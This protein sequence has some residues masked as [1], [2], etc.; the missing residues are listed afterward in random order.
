MAIDLW[1][2]MA[3]RGMYVL[4]LNEDKMAEECDAAQ[5]CKMR[6]QKQPEMDSMNRRQAGYIK[7]SAATMGRRHRERSVLLAKESVQK[8]GDKPRE[9][10]RGPNRFHADR[11]EHRKPLSCNVTKKLPDDG[12]A[13]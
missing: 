1:F 4:L 12:S 5:Q 2:N 7:Q 10:P 9:L 11:S 3:S 8:E 13:E 6:W